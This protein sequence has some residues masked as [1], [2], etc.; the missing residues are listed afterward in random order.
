[1][2]D[3]E[4]EFLDTPLAFRSRPLALTVL[5]PPVATAVEAR[6]VEEV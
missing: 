3:G 5:A 6:V 1:M 2:I 4:V